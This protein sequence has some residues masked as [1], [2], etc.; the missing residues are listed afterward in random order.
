MPSIEIKL[1]KTGSQTS[2]LAGRAFV[3]LVTIILADFIWEAIRDSCD[4]LTNKNLLSWIQLLFSWIVLSVIIAMQ[5]PK[6]MTHVVVYSSLIGLLISAVS[7]LHVDP[8]KGVG[9]YI[10]DI[11]QSLTA[12]IAA[13]VS[14]YSVSKA[15]KWYPKK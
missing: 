5:V 12:T 10:V 1:P 4:T 15:L 11:L 2:M 13:G 7:T 9:T 14:I 8:K 3:G 6:N